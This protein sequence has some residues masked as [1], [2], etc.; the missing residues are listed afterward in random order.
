MF[1][2]QQILSDEQVTTFVQQ[3][4]SNVEQYSDFLSIKRE[5]YKPCNSEI[6]ERVFI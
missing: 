4:I 2:Q 5:S 6:E 3:K 1:V